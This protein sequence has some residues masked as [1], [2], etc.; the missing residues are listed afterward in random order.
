[1]LAELLEETLYKGYSLMTVL[2]QWLDVIWLPLVLLAA[3]KGHRIFALAFVAAC[4]VMLRLQVE[5]I[6]STGYPT[7]YLGILD[8]PVFQRGLIVYGVFILIYMLL[9]YFSPGARRIVVMAASLS[10]F[11]TAMFISTIVMVL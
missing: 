5:L 1:M 2:Y 3:H 11:F 7:G 8:N 9:A 4:I 6:V 10:L